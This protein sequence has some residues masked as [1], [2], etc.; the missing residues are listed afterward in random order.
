VPSQ[1]TDAPGMRMYYQDSLAYEVEVFIIFGLVAVLITLYKLYR[2]DTTQREKYFLLVGWAIIPPVWFVIEY[3]FVFL[4]YGA[5]NSFKFFDYG[6]SVASK[7]WGAVS[8]LIA[9]VIYKDSEKEKEDKAERKE[10]EDAEDLKA[11]PDEFE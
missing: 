6:Q 7:L 10:K 8:T 5:E 11:K 3:F 4:P 1:I 2:K 9:L